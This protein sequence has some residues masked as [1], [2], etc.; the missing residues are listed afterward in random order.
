MPAVVDSIRPIATGVLDISPKTRPIV[1]VLP[2]R[3]SS[4]RNARPPGHLLADAEDGKSCEPR[5]TGAQGS[6]DP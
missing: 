2:D 4:S 5:R 6:L 3:S 1:C